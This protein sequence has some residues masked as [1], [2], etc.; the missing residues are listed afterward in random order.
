[1]LQCKV[2]DDSV[3]GAPEMAPI[4]PRFRRLPPPAVDG[5]PPAPCGMA[6]TSLG[7]AASRRFY[8]AS[9]PLSPSAN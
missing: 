4:G 6:P 5:H 9:M 2:Y 7:I 1:M 3:S 8:T